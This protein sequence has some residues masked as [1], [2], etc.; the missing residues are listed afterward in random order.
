MRAVSSL[1]SKSSLLTFVSSFSLD[2]K[3]IENVINYEMPKSIE[4]YLHRV[5]R[6]ARAGQKGRYVST[7]LRLVF[8]RTAQLLTPSWTRSALTLVGE[9]DRKLVKLAMKHA[10]PESIKQRTIPG[11]VVAVV[12]KQ[13]R[14]L[15]PDVRDVMQEEKEEKEVRGDALSHGPAAHVRTRD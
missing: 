10:P 11:V 13:F 4:I 2:I 3:G 9:S 6:T 8:C 7:S 12:S 15:E 1:A 5:G 14:A